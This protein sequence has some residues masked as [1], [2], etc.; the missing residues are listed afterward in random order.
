MTA[1]PRAPVDPFAHV[2]YSI[3]EPDPVHGALRTA[4]PLVQ[5]EAPAGGPVW[6]VTDENLAREVLAHDKIVKDPAFAPPHWNRWAVGLEPTASEQPSLTT[7][8][9]PR[10]QRLRRAHTPLLSARRVHA[11]ADR[12]A[13]IARE[14]LA[15][16]AAHE[17]PVDLTADFTTRF[18][19]TVVCDL[20]GMPLDRVDA[21][22]T[23]CRQVLT[24]VPEVFTAAMSAFD[25]LTAAALQSGTTGL[26]AQLRER[27]PAEITE[28]QLRYLPFGL[29]FAGQITTEAALGFL[30]APTTRTPTSRSPTT[31]SSARAWESTGAG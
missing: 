25:E 1:A 5:A 13:A 16:L 29:V 8:D 28:S 19:L 3:T 20:I 7:L 22:A 31:S 30:L 26:A 18:P 2:R 27:V 17:S 24:D 15:D 4:G 14:L 23:A 6:I 11:H 12:I 21:A 10:H 9:G